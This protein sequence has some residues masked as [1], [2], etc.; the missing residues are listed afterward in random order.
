MASFE[1][2]ANMSP[3]KEASS[4]LC[5]QIIV[6]V[7]IEVIHQVLPI[8]QGLRGLHWYTFDVTR[9]HQEKT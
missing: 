2:D 1:L 8:I 7:T 3:F 6:Y 4:E 5:I 9:L